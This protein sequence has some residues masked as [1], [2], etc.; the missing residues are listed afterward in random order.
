MYCAMT[1]ANVKLRVIR[2]AIIVILSSSERGS[3]M[4][5]VTLGVDRIFA[6]TGTY[7]VLSWFIL[8][9]LI[10]LHQIRLVACVW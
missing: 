2:M 9:R 6:V 3:A 4:A 5:A 1:S 7:L 10:F 8:F